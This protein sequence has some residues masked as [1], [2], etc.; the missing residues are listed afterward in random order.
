MVQVSDIKDTIE[1]IYEGNTA[2]EMLLEFEG[3]L[4]NLH[5]YAFKNWI[6]GEVV[7]GPH[8][9]RYWVEATLMYPEKMMPDPDGAL[10]LT[11]HGCYVYF[12]KEDFIIN[13]D[14]KSPEDLETN[15]RGERKP[16][17]VK[18]PV[19]LVKIVMPRHFVDEFNSS[20]IEVNGVDIDLSDVDDAYSEGLD[21]EEALQQ[22]NIND[23]SE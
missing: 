19:W 8:I 1:S 2:L 22:D 16:K 13:V 18:K 12:Q 15:D 23:T 4:D 17:K 3:I 6:N 20:K 14:I 21:G 10:R 5:L 11:K 7:D 9:S